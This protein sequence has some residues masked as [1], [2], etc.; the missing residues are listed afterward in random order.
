MKKTV[1]YEEHIRNKAKMVEFAGYIMP[2]EYS[3]IAGEHREVRT[4]SGLFDVS[5]MGEIKITGMETMEFVNYLLTNDIAP[6]HEKSM[7]YA[8][9]LKEDGGVVDDLMVYKFNNEY[10]LLVVNASNKDKDY[11]WIKAHRHKFNVQVEDVSSYYSQLALQGPLAAGILQEFTDYCLDDLKALDFDN[12]MIHGSRFLVSRSGYTGEDGFEI[13]GANHNILNLFLELQ[14]HPDITLCGL[15][16]RDTLRFEAAMPLYGHEIG[17]DINPLEAGLSFAV[18]MHKDFIGRP[19]LSSYRERTDKRK[20]VA[21]QLLEKGIARADYPVAVDGRVIGK[22]TTGYMIPGNDK[23]YAFA[24]VP[25]AYAAL[26]TIVDV[27]IRKNTVKA[28]VRN[29]KF[30]QKK[31]IK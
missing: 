16:C 7:A 24:L 3:G 30:I 10:C 12:I 8:L 6:Y 29:K 23:A 5:H 4:R 17:P 2:L 21:L 25:E 28:R 9:M 1:L 26:G 14:E 13:Y 18:K 11:E 27:H 20:V 22:I 15:G 19:A 31:N